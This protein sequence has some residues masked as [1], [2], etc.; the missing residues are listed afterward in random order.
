MLYVAA[1]CRGQCERGQEK[2]G[3]LFSY[4]MHVS[5]DVNMTYPVQFGD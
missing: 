2:G 3:G 4:C 5:R 1:F